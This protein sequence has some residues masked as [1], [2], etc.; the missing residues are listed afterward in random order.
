MVDATE[1]TAVALGYVTLASAVDKVKHPNFAEG[2]ACG[3]CALYQG[4]VGSAAGPCPLFTGKQVAAKGW[5][6]SYVKKTT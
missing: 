2:S 3:N 6:A 5:C 4:A 1:P